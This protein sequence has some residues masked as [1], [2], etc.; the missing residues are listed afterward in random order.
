MTKSLLSIPEHKRTEVALRRASGRTMGNGKLGALDY[1]VK[2]G[3]KTRK[4]IE[5]EHISRMAKSIKEDK[6]TTKSDR[7]QQRREKI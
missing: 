5:A 4:E 7:R 6:H 3:I 1:L 2:K